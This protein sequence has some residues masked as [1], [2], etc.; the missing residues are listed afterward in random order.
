ML[1]FSE[2]INDAFRSRLES[3]LAGWDTSQTDVGTAEALKAV[4]RLPLAD[5]EQSL[6][7]YIVSDFRKR[8]FATT[9]DV[10]KP[11]TDLA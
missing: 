5:D 2:R 1:V 3:L 6:I 11:L 4:P 9:S 7:L 10:R 8:Q